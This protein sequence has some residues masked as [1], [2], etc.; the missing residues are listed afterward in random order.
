MKS[1][2]EEIELLIRGCNDINEVRG[3][4]ND[5]EKFGNPFVQ[6]TELLTKYSISSS[7]LS[8]YILTSN[9][10]TLTGLINKV[11]EELRIRL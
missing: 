11:K 1:K 7:V 4:L 8:Y 6:D 3:K 9:D 5:I 10:E 2:I